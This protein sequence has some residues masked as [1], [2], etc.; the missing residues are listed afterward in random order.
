MTDL[1][2]RAI[3]ELEERNR[4][5]VAQNIDLQQEN[6]ELKFKQRQA[7]KVLRKGYQ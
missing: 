3:R 2:K 1:K 5:L 6:E 4:R 7:L